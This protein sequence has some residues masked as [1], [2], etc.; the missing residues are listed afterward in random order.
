MSTWMEKWEDIKEKFDCP[1]DLESYFRE[2]KIG[3]MMVDILD[4]GSIN[5]SSGKIIT[6]DPFID[7]E[8]ASSYIQ[9][10]PVGVYKTKICV[11]PSEEW[12]DRYAC[13]KVEINENLPKR[14]ELAMVGSEDIES[15]IEE[16][17]YYGFGVD[18]GMG[19]IADEKAQRAFKDFWEERRSKDNSI[20]PYNNLFCDLLE[21]NAGAYPKYQMEYGDWLNC[22]IP[23]TDKNIL[24][25]ASG[26][27]DG[28][29]PTYFGYDENNDI[30][31]IYIQFF[32]IE[33]SYKD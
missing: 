4:I 14:Y 2:K 21:E 32:D 28:Y 1:M 17:E 5:I 24:I 23:D 19:C 12:G 22:R 20:D 18:A 26:W 29:Y 27:G 11:V 3:G 30:C 33:E 7:L 6:C 8:D 25:F 10:V 13:V 15:E 9:R 16:G 31:G